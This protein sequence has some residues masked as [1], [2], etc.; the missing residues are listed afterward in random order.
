MKDEYARYKDEQLAELRRL[1][2][3]A[4]TR[5]EAKLRQASRE[6]VQE[7][8]TELKQTIETAQ[9]K[10]VERYEAAMKEADDMEAAGTPAILVEHSRSFAK[11]S[12]ES[13]TRFNKTVLDEFI[14]S[15]QG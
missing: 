1:L 5:L 10:A 8:I 4:V 3:A 6:F 13:V 12:L 9:E 11:T 15:V 2:Q 14:Q 7:K